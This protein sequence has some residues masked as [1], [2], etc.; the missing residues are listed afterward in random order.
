MEFKTQESQPR[1]SLSPL[2][3]SVLLL[4]KSNLQKMTSYGVKLLL[5]L[6][7]NWEATEHLLSRLVP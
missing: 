6:R 4:V 2:G 7:G 1:Q 3:D 5:A